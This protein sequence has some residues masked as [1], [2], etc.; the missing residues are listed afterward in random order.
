M[1]AVTKY[2]RMSAQVLST[3]LVLG[4]VTLMWWRWQAQAAQPSYEVIPVRVRE[5]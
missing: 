4:T 3:A 5:Q 2:K 1:K